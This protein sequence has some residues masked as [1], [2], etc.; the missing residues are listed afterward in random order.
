MF[1]DKPKSFAFKL[2]T[3]RLRRF[4]IDT[5]QNKT[6]QTNLSCAIK[7]GTYHLEK[8]SPMGGPQKHYRTPTYRGIVPKV[9]SK[10]DSYVKRSVLI[11]ILICKTYYKL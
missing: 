8:C 2:A 11:S 10:I 4:R 5:P 6:F 7:T 3:K 1:I 9:R